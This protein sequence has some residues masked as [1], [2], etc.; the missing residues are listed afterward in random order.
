MADGLFISLVGMGAVF[1]SLTIIMFLMVGIERVFRDE[2]VIGEATLAVGDAVALSRSVRETVDPEDSVDV[3]AITLALASHMKKQ[4]KQ[5]GMSVVINDIHYKVDAGEL[6]CTPVV[7]VV[8]GESY[9]GSVGD[10][11]LSFAE[12]A[13]LKIG[14]QVRDPQRERIWRTAYPP[15]RGGYWSRSGWTGRHGV[16]TKGY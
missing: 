2:E 12:K 9:W 16:G 3:A 11:G 14:M 10:D 13:F 8:N 6:S 4:G 5:L 7:V 1:V 15:S